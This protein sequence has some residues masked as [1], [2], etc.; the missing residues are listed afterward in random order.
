MGEINFY[1]TD[2]QVTTLKELWG[3]AI[4]AREIGEALGVSRNAILG[5]VHRLELPQRK[6]TPAQHPKNR[7]PSKPRPRPSRA[8]VRIAPPPKPLP[9][10]PLEPPLSRNI[11]LVD[12]ESNQ[13]RFIAGEPRDATY[14]GHQTRGGSK[15]C[16]Y[17]F[18][19]VYQP[20]QIR[21]RRM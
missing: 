17:H 11:R 5:K 1:W 2:A 21:K 20:P 15:W 7:I 14:C 6:R 16:A 13:C 18:G 12:L 8:I 10:P 9:P 4:V 3:Q 19:V